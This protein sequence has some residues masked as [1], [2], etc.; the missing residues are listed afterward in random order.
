LPTVGMGL[1]S[2]VMTPVQA[3]GILVIP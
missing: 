2:I 1:L 3:A